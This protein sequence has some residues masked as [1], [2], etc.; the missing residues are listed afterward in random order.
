MK[1]GFLEP[2]K[3]DAGEWNRAAATHFLRRAGF[4]PAPGDVEHALDVGFEAALEEFIARDAHDPAL[5]GGVLHLLAA[6]SAD[7]LAAWWMGERESTHSMSISP[8]SCG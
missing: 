4:G 8:H 3:P 7:H 5:Q 6:G 2:W 1:S